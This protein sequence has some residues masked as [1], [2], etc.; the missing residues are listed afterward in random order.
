MTALEEF[1]K[2]VEGRS[3]P[4]THR[5]FKDHADHIVCSDDVRLSVQASHLHYCTPRDDW[6]PYSKVEVGFPGIRPPETW[7][8]YCWDWDKPTETVYAFVPVGLVREFILDHS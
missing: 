6:G 3:D 4:R 2:I 8:E 1:E 5:G 7:R